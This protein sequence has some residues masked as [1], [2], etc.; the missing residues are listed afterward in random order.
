METNAKST[1]QNEL[2]KNCNKVFTISSNIICRISNWF[3]KWRSHILQP[4]LE[5]DGFGYSYTILGHFRRAKRLLNND[6]P[7]LLN[8]ISIQY[9]NFINIILLVNQKDV[10]KIQTKIE[11]LNKSWKQ[12]QRIQNVKFSRIG[13]PNRCGYKFW[14]S[15]H[16]LQTDKLHCISTEY[17]VHS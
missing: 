17:R 1:H 4:V 13:T 14:Q 7:A 11:M 5:L 15:K 3:Y 12:P 8:K 6:S 2:S 10:V 16:V 9:E